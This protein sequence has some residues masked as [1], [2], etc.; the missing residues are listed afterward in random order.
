MRRMIGFCSP[1]MTGISMGGVTFGRPWGP[2]RP[3]FSPFCLPLSRASLAGPAAGTS[4]SGRVAGERS[5]GV[6][7][8]GEAALTASLDGA[9]GRS[10]T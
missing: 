8:N 6:D 4:S 1:S 2:C 3:G 7:Q 5:S 10:W 9:G